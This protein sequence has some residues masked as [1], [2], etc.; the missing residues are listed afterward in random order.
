MK[1]ARVEPIQEEQEEPQL[2]QEFQ[3]CRADQPYCTF[4]LYDNGQVCYNGRARHGDWRY[5]QA[6]PNSFESVSYTHLT[7]PTKRIV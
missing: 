3:Y 1:R 7:L 2:L 5:H 4:C 6:D